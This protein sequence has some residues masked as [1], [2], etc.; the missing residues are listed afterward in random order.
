MAKHVT[1]TPAAT[2]RPGD[3]LAGAGLVLLAGVGYGAVAILARVAYEGGSNAPTSLVVRFGLAGV[4]FWVIVAASGRL[5]RLPGRRIGGFALMGLLFSSGSIMSFMAVE[6]IPAALASLVFYIYP[7][8]VTL[9]SVLF[10]GTRFSRS[11][12]VILAVTLLGCALTVDVEAGPVD[13]LGLA[14][15]IATG[16]AYAGYVLIGSRAAADVP[17][18]TA[19]AWIISVAGL[20]MLV[21]GVTGLFGDELTTDISPRG[22]AAILAL[23][24]FSTVVSISAFLAGLTR[25]DP[26]R[27]SILSTIEPVVAVI[28]AAI[29]LDERLSL[30]QAL[31]GVVIVSAALAL[32]LLARR[33]GRYA[34]TR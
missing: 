4:I 6:R 14:L 8:V 1:A 32:Q 13:A 2:S 25:L 18:L 9:G 20:L 17:P 10:F 19:S 5:R 16:V 28:L 11:R 30:Q 27:A 31:G 7:A 22:W 23:A 33:E 15:A 24:L 26:Y 21:V 29:L 34:S 12:L 3:A